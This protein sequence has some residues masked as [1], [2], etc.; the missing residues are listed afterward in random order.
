M[1]FFSTKNFENIPNVEDD[2][3]TEYTFKTW[4]LSESLEKIKN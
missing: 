3:I 2:V 1:N 4:K